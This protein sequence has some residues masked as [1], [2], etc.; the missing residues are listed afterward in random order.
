MRKSLNHVNVQE[1]LWR[2]FKILNRVI[3][4]CTRKLQ[5]FHGK[6]EGQVFNFS[7]QVCNEKNL[8]NSERANHEFI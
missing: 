8:H 7:F 5:I 2:T 1:I 4:G 6:G 3:E